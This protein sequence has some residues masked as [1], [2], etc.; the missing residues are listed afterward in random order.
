M[1]EFKDKLENYG[2]DYKNVEDRFMKNKSLYLR[3][4]DM[5]LEDTNME[6]LKNALENGDIQM[7]FEAAHTLKGVIGNMGFIPLYEKICSIVEPLRRED[8]NIDYMPLYDEIVT[9]FE[10]VRELRSGLE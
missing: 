3:C 7:A 1:N 10:K 5:L 9:E 4:F 8:K 6:N 2:V